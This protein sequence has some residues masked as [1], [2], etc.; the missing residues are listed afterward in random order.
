MQSLL[1]ADFAFEDRD[2]GYARKPL[3]LPCTYVLGAVEGRTAPDVSELVDDDILFAAG[4]EPGG[5]LSSRIF[6]TS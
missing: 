5:Y 1:A 4:I 6:D 2:M 3:C